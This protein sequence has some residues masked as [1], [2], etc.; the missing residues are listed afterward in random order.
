MKKRPLSFCTPS[1]SSFS[2]TCLFYYS[3]CIILVLLSSPTRSIILA[4]AQQD[5]SIGILDTLFNNNNTNFTQCS[6]VNTFVVHDLNRTY[7]HA[8]NTFFFNLSGHSSIAV[9]NLNQGQ[10]RKYDNF[11]SLSISIFVFLK[12]I[13]IY[14]NQLN[15]SSMFYFK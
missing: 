15:A 4:N 11:L 2:I 5:Q 1:S 12:Y 13:Y 3:L 6:N 8:T 9:T 14:I 10:N 7:D